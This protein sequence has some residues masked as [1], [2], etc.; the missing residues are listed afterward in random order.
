MLYFDGGCKVAGAVSK[1]IGYGDAKDSKDNK[2]N[3][4]YMDYMDYKDPPSLKLRWASAREAGKDGADYTD[5]ADEF[6]RGRV[7]GGGEGF[8]KRVDSCTILV[9]TSRGFSYG[10]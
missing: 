9:T 7:C 2:D 6:T 3:K 4:D 1:T 8:A 10:L 5:S